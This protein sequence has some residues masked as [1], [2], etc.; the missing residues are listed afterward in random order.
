MCFSVFLVGRFSQPSQLEVYQVNFQDLED[1]DLKGLELVS[2]QKQVVVTKLPQI[3]NLIDEKVK[4]IAVVITAKDQEVYL[5]VS[6]G[7]MDK[8]KD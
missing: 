3:D 4:N 2:N 6:N 1:L 5:V 8:S 7:R